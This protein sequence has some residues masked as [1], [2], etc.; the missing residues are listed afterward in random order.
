MKIWEIDFTDG[1]EY[2]CSNGSTYEICNGDLLE[3]CSDITDCYTLSELFEL[4]FEEVV[5]DWSKVEAD[6][7]VLV[8]DDG[9]EWYN[10]YF[11]EFKNGK[12]HCYNGG[13]NLWSTDGCMET[14][15]YAK[16]AE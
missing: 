2:K 10:R 9:E 14:W 8:S 13:A 16:L 1:K 7:K 3:H 6:T 4:D 11:A 12:V 15:S 5:I